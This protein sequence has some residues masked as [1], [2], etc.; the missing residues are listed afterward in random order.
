MGSDLTVKRIDEMESIWGGSFVRA[1]ASLGA[2]SFG[3]NVLNL[4][5][6]YNQYFVHN[7]VD[8]PVSDDLEEVYTA[9]NGKATLHVGGEEHVLEPGVFARVGAAETR[10]VTTGAESAQ[11][12]II[13]GTPGKAYQPLPI[14]ELGGPESL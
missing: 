14:V 13:G 11:L 2:S 6:N 12:L 5:P 8:P 3:M 4:P 7:H 10:N 1:R 9:L